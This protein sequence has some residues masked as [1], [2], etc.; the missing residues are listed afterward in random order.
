ML[1]TGRLSHT[2][3]PAELHHRLVWW[4]AA[5]I[6]EQLAGTDAG[7]VIADAALRALGGHD[8][9]DRIEGAA[10]RLASAID[11]QPGEL[12]ALLT[13][14]LGDRSLA[15]F[16]ALLAFALRSISRSCALVVGGGDPFWLALRATT[17]TSHDRQIGLAL[18]SDVEA[19]ADQI[20]TIMAVD[21]A[22]ARDT[23]AP[24]MLPADF[25][26]AIAA[27]AAAR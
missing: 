18:S 22:A 25:R 11:P 14:A 16:V 2:E 21:P 13:H 10:T 17:W 8:E 6:H 15:L 19:F 1:D 23:L 12:P 27:L 9:S 4:I 20:D 3:L 24:L 7:R 5:A 26:A